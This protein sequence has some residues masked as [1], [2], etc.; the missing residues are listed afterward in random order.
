MQIFNRWGVLVYETNGY[1]GAN[2]Q[3]NVFK[4]IS[5]GRVTIKES[6]T[7][8]TGTYYYILERR[9]GGGEVLKDSGY[10]YI[11]RK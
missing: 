8:P 10:L 5:E 9:L 7:L 2:G 4:G 11:N 6:K 1:G 3:T